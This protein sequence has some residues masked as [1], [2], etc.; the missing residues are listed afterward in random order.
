MSPCPSDSTLRSL[1]TDAL[2]DAGYAAIEEHVENCPQCKAA[3]E[4]LVRGGPG[5]PDCLP[6]PEQWP[7]IPGFEIRRELGRGPMSV[8]YQAWQPRLKRHVAL[9]IVRSGP[10]FGS[11]ERDRWLRKA[12]AYTCVRHPNVVPLHE[13]GE[14]P[15]WLYLVLEYMPGGSLKHRL[16]VPYAAGDAARL[17]EAIA[18]AVAA[19]HAEGLVHLDLKPSNI[20]LDLDPGQPREEAAPRVGDFGISLAG[21]TPMPAWQR[22]AWPGHWER[23]RT[24]RRSKSPAIGRSSA[25]RRISMAWARCSTMC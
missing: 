3:L 8:V 10:G 11:R 15:P 21:P 24:W 25:R 6:D 14:A 1:G 16:D 20:M 4:R 7:Q 13:A 17:L 18:Q 23:P 19:I 9:K 12:Q 22:T 5:P 2:A